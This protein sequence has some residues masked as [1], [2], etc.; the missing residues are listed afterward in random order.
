MKLK[1]L[2]F[3]LV[4][5]FSFKS[6]KN[7]PQWEYYGGKADGNK[8]SE[9]DQINIG[10]VKDL[11][12]AWTFHSEKS[13][14]GDKIKCNPLI[15]DRVFYGTTDLK[16]VVALDPVTGVQK[17]IFRPREFDP[18]GSQGPARGL[19]HWQEGTEKRLFYV[20]GTWLYSVDA[21]TGKLDEKFGEKGKIH[22]AK[23]LGLNSD[24]IVSQ[25]TPGIIFKNLLICGSFVSE[26]LPAAPGDIRAIDVRTGEIAWIFHTIPHPGEFGYETWPKDAYKF[27]GG[28]NN[29]GGMSLD[30]KREI[31]YIPLASPTYDFYGVNREG[32]NLYGNCLMALDA[33]TGKRIWHYQITHHDLWD[34]D[35]PCQPNLI[36]VNHE[37]KNIDAVAQV[38][39][40]GFV[41]VFDRETG[42]PLFDIIEKPVPAS[43][44]AGE[45]AW[46]TQPIPVKPAPFARQELSEENITDITPEANKYVK[47]ELKKY[48]TDPYSPPS[49]QGTVV[50]PFF[51]GGASW[52]GAAFDPNSEL[53]VVN[54]TE[55]PWLLKLIDLKTELSK[56][57][58]DGK[59]LYKSY[60]AG[61]HG[62]SKEGGHYVPELKSV[63]KKYSFTQVADI[64]KK[65]KGVMPSFT[66]L[67]E[68]QQ[69][70]IVSFVLNFKPKPL[71]NT[72]K[73]L[74][75]STLKLDDYNLPYTN[76]GY[77]KFVDKE[78]YPAIK[79]P[80]GTLTGIDLNK[81]EI[82]WQSVL[83]EHKELTKR[84]IP[85][86]GMKSE[87]GPIVTKSGLTFI[88]G[89]QD[90][91]FRAF[92]TR[93]GKIVWEYDL[94]GVGNATP[95]TYEINGTQYIVL[96]VSERK[97]NGHQGRYVAFRL[98]NNNK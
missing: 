15:I 19:V 4:T 72:S 62:E 38:T 7:L 96:A 69:N 66:Y 70:A 52:G 71:K 74:A 36:S 41:Y 27:L 53:L 73:A 33:N 98:K 29:W 25:T 88:A 16:D 22:F 63:G 90:N 9:L 61:C 77:T 34:R 12:V 79:P 85:P 60:C 42:K 86:T 50:M 3:F 10:N 30:T 14:N 21:Q 91:M 26:Y 18:K 78:G 24:K 89:T 55:I 51:N 97:E 54:S 5:I 80:W 87:G 83:G 49:L 95:A 11:E 75:S 17:W 20:F 94:K 35:L 84:G 58:N 65:G 57:T 28:V 39:K 44:I 56:N 93:T 45:K 68:S 13:E 31:V 92:E 37:G 47:Q 6:T 1:I 46:K 82:V 43:T 32:Q 40:T 67:S 48:I 76:Q 59:K 23:G 2:Y 81:G 8:Y 64:V